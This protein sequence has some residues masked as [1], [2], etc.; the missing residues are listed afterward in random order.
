[1]PVS[2]RLEAHDSMT[3]RTRQGARRSAARVKTASPPSFRELRFRTWVARL[4]SA[5][6]LAATGLTIRSA[7]PRARVRL[8]EPAGAAIG[9]GNRATPVPPHHRISVKGT[10]VS[11]RALRSQGDSPDSPRPKNYG[12]FIASRIISSIATR[13]KPLISRKS[14]NSRGR[15]AYSFQRSS[16]DT[17]RTRLS[18][19]PSMY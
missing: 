3:R 7:T 14:S 11:T 4:P 9:L 10:T 15:P 2:R 16:T 1:L 19:A 13:A 8:S 12:T 5:S 18:Q 6:L 17:R